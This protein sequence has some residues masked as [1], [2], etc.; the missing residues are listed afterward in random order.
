M[1]LEKKHTLVPPYKKVSLTGIQEIHN[2]LKAE[3]DI[4]CYYPCEWSWEWI[5]T[6]GS[7]RGKLP[8]RIAG[9]IKS[10]YGL[11]L[12]PEQKSAVGNL[13]RKHLLA[14][15]NYTIDFTDTFDWKSGDFGDRG[16]CFWGCNRS[17]KEVMESEGVIAIRFYDALGYTGIG[18]AWLYELSEGAWVLFNA[19]GL[20]C[21]E[22]A[23]VFA[24]KMQEDDGGKWEYKE[25]GSLDID[26][27]SG[28]LVYINNHP[29]IVYREGYDPE[30]YVDL[31]WDVP[32]CPCESCGDWIH[33]D[34]TNYDDGGDPLCGECYEEL[35]DQREE[36]R[37]FE[38]EEAKFRDA[39]GRA[40]IAHTFT[41]EAIRQAI[42]RNVVNGQLPMNLGI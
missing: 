16:S 41:Q 7:Y 31:D 19:Y 42:A 23:S 18:R 22:A 8:N 28:G 10:Y 34:E 14:Q 29:Q 32:Y 13:A 3:L 27:W 38:L 17:A 40:E 9:R 12:T 11:K 33:E 39:A 4:L 6:R 21:P 35:L 37:L 5:Y 15:E 30:C 24:M 25:L 36:I 1:E 26:G 2:Y 20:E